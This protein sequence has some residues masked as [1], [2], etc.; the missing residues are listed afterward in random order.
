VQLHSIVQVFHLSVH[1]TDWARIWDFDFL[2]LATLG[3]A[4]GVKYWAKVTQQQ[5][6]Q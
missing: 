1:L 4:L 5:E 2:R 6:E 3:F